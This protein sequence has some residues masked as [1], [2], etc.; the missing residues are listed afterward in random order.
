MQLT[1]RKCKDTTV[2]LEEKAESTFALNPGK[3]T[4]LYLLDKIIFPVPKAESAL[5]QF[6]EKSSRLFLLTR[7]FNFPFVL[8]FEP[9]LDLVFLIHIVPLLFVAP[10]DYFA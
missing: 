8:S 3:P 7:F 9:L 5:G 6:L 2:R 10:S 1:Q 4:R